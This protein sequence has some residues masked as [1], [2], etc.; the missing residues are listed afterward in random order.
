MINNYILPFLC[1]IKQ[2]E[3]IVKL[4]FR[5]THATSDVRFK[6]ESGSNNNLLNLVKF[7]VKFP[8]QSSMLYEMIK[9][10]MIKLMNEASD[11]GSFVEVLVKEKQAFKSCRPIVDIL[12]QRRQWLEKKLRERP[13]FSWKMPNAKM[14]NHPKIEQF[15]WSDQQTLVYGNLNDHSHLRN[16]IRKYSNSYSWG[17]GGYS[18]EM[19]EQPGLKV[20]IKKTR[21]WFDQ[22]D[23]EFVSYSSEFERIKCFLDS[24]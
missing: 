22:K 11:F 13:Q 5:S 10:S 19:K 7:L 4:A 3:E 14:P 9:T 1:N 8:E 6:F 2:C 17:D 21:H 20:H 23:R 12:E 18:V 16:F 24:K 15:L